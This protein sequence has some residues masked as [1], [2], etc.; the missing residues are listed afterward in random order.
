MLRRWRCQATKGAR[1]GDSRRRWGK[2]EEHT[3]ELQSHVNLVCRLLLEK[4]KISRTSTTVTSRTR[5]KLAR[6]D[7]EPAHRLPLLS[8][9]LAPP[10]VDD[11]PPGEVPRP[12][13]PRPRRARA[14]YP[15]TSK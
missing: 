15:T 3:S 2:S 4:K 12:L 14:S 8:R 1:C 6:H 13:C 11:P 9:R 10:L 5:S 7:R